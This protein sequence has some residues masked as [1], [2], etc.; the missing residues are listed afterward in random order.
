MRRF[1]LLTMVTALVL[2]TL[3][4]PA[5]AHAQ[6]TQQAT[7]SPA[8]EISTPFPAKV[9][10]I[11]EEL[12]L[13]LNLRGNGSSK[14][15]NLQMQDVPAN[16][17][18]SFRGNGRMVNSV[19]VLPNEAAEVDLRIEPPADVQSG[20]YNFTVLAD[21]GNGS[22]ASLPLQM[23][24]QDRLPPKLAIE[25]ERPTLRGEPGNAL[26]FDVS[27]RNEGDTDMTVDLNAQ[28]PGGFTVT[29]QSGGQDVTNLPI[30]GGA[31]ERVTVVAEPRD[32]VQ[33]G[34]YPFSITA[35]SDA[36]EANIPLTA[37]LVG[38]ANLVFTT[39]DARL[40]GQATLGSDNNFKLTVRN[41]GTAPVRDISL[42]ASAPTGWTTT[43]DPPT[44][45]EL[46]PGQQL[47]VNANVRP[48]DQAVAGDYVLNFSAR[49]AEGTTRTMDFRVTAVTSTWWGIVGV[50]LIAVAIGVV[51]MA[52]MRFG[53]R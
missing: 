31:T 14:I 8:L 37:E 43:F 53:R 49:P 52:V 23:T 21:D 18:V 28:A 17:N 22:R 11:G 46:G 47:E 40:S 42:N 50:V 35:R 12:T 7:G 51:G 32:D 48:A 16:W 4:L 34:S 1:V 13:D 41:D 20:T 26:R 27:L 19:F 33:A 15:V 25:S 24:V 45:T 2:P 5:A 6:G 39:P 3:L 29:F 10:G 9:I 38:R 30:S 36:A 44:I